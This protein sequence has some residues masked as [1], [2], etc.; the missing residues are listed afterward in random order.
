MNLFG[1]DETGAYTA[2][3]YSRR[4]KLYVEKIA[5]ENQGLF[6]EAQQEVKEDNTFNRSKLKEAEEAIIRLYEQ[7]LQEKGR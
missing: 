5:P 2:E 4:F 6:L 7:K 1:D 3:N